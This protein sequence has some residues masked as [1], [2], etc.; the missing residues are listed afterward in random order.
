VLVATELAFAV[1]EVTGPVPCVT[2][3]QPEC[4]G[5]V[6]LVADTPCSVVSTPKIPTASRTF[7][8]NAAICVFPNNEEPLALPTAATPGCFGAP[9]AASD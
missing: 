1:T 5:C 8:L 4:C 3:T 9:A 7:V 6:L 2:R